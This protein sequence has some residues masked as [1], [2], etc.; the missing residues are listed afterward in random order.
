MVYFLVFC[1]RQAFFSPPKT[2]KHLHDRGMEKAWACAN[3][4]PRW[5]HSAA[6]F[7]WITIS[8]QLWGL[9]SP[10]LLFPLPCLSKRLCEIRSLLVNEPA[11]DT[12]LPTLILDVTHPCHFPTV[13]PK[14]LFAGHKSRGSKVS[15]PL[16]ECA[17]IGR[18]RLHQQLSKPHRSASKKSEGWLIRWSSPLRPCK[19]RLLSAGR[20]MALPSSC[21]NCLPI[22]PL[23][24][25]PPPPTSAY[26]DRGVEWLY[27][28]ADAVCGPA[29]R[30]LTH[31]HRHRG[32]R[33][34]ETGLRHS[35]PFT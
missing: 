29:A 25:P 2:N 16:P 6:C 31:E 3:C 19:S 7:V 20:I 1:V 8:S 35:R 30:P 13:C 28:W 26:C 18:R 22:V 9:P 32:T 14:R 15:W 10:S 17:I 34:C 12:Y 24:L 27:A 11:S 4:W 21:N 23:A 5:L 33:V